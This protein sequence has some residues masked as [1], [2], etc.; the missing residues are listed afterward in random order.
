MI[1]ALIWLALMS[2]SVRR[3]RSDAG[4]LARH[5]AGLDNPSPELLR[6]AWI[7]NH[8]VKDAVRKLSSHA[9]MNM[10]AFGLFI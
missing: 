7:E 10:G 5:L 3:S 2:R 1:A 8:H 6:S 9:L 4:L